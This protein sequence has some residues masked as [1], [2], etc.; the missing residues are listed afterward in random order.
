LNFDK[1]SFDNEYLDSNLNWGTNNCY[2]KE[3]A[4]QRLNNLT[5]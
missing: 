1:S 3:D 2:I 4:S 5:S